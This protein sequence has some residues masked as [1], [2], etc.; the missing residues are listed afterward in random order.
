MANESKLP[1]YKKVIVR[2]KLEKIIKLSNKYYQ[3]SILCLDTNTFNEKK[4]CDL[5]VEYYR[6]CMKLFDGIYNSIKDDGKAAFPYINLS[7]NLGINSVSKPNDF[8]AEMENMLD[9]FDIDYDDSSLIGL[10]N[11]YFDS[12]HRTIL[13]KD[14]DTLVRNFYL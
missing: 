8:R 4:F 3:Y 10:I 11:I 13:G 5:R 9:E 6:K 1:F 7:K 2:H 12:R 14:L